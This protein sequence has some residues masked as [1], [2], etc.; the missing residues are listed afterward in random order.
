MNAVGLNLARPLG[1]HPPGRKDPQFYYDAKT[2]VLINGIPPGW[3]LFT[4]EEE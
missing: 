3:A 1:K 2:R 4:L